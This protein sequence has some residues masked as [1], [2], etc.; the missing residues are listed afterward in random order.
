MSQAIIQDRYTGQT[1]NAVRIA[2]T[3]ASGLFITLSPLAGS[4]LQRLAGWQASF[5]VFICLVSLALLL[6][7]HPLRERR[8]ASQSSSVTKRY[9]VLLRDARFMVYSLLSA[10]A[11]ACHFSFIVV[12][13]LL[14]MDR[15]E[16]SE[17]GFSLVFLGYGG[18]YVLGGLVAS[19]LNQRVRAHIQ[20]HIGLGLIGIAGLVLVFWLTHAALSVASLLVPMIICT[21]GTTLVRPAATT[22]ALERHPDCA[23]TAAAL[24]NTLLFAIGGLASGLV[25]LLEGSLPMS[26]SIVFIGVGLGGAVVLRGLSPAQ[27]TTAI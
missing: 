20:M 10:L 21:A 16:L 17:Y 25:A 19:V 18:A 1:R 15:L 8:P 14:L 22:A 4:A 13:P 11:F 27:S 3:T 23:G 9:P 24:C 26:L 7:A 2:M 5:Y 12:S 6:S